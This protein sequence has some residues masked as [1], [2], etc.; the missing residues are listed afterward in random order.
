[1]SSSPRTSA[2]KGVSCGRFPSTSLP[3]V[4]PAPPQPTP[5]PDCDELGLTEPCTLIRAGTASGG[6]GE[7][8]A[9]P[10]TLRAFGEEIAGVMV[11]ID[12]LDVLSVPAI[13][14]GPRPLPRCT[15]NPAIDKNG[16]GIAYRPP[17][18]TVGVDCSGI[19]VL[20]ISLHDVDPIPDGS[21][22]FT[23]EVDIAADAA[24]GTYAVPVFD[25]EA[26]DPRGNPIEI[27]AADGEVIVLAPGN[28]GR[29]AQLAPGGGCAIA[30]GEAPDALWLG[31][32]AAVALVARSRWR[33]TLILL[34]ASSLSNHRRRGSPVSTTTQPARSARVR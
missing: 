22:L 17:G 3:E 25:T 15:V 4:V 18:C 10:F 2:P 8:V 13:D 30:T 14:S 23:C 5:P 29:S 19:R 20:L 12:F 11:D 16:G 31:A 6:P 9:L 21:E 28:S 7:R 1:M 34:S 27:D 26:S 32:I 33:A 24:P